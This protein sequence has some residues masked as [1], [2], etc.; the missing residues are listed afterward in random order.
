MLGEGQGEAG[1]ENG[2]QR[3]G[4]LGRET[5]GCGELVFR[6]LRLMQRLG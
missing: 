6:E 5:A 1:A 3:R 2:A 4:S